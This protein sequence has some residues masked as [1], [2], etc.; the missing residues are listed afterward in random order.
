MLHC[1]CLTE[2]QRPMPLS[3]GTALVCGAILL[4]V[5]Q[6]LGMQGSCGPSHSENTLMMSV[7]SDVCAP[8]SL[9]LADPMLKGDCPVTCN[10]S[11]Y[12]FRLSQPLPCL[13]RQPPGPAAAAVHAGPMWPWPQA[14]RCCPPGTSQTGLCRSLRTP[15]AAPGWPA[16]PRT[17]SVHMTDV[18]VTLAHQQL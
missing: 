6:W 12:K 18:S 16:A 7:H 2:R 13:W 15:P 5:Q 10:Q 4:V 1:R 17:L 11:T 8:K 9:Q 14:P 3:A